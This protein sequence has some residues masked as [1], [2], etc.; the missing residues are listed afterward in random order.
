MSAE[1]TSVQADPLARLGE[2]IETAAGSLGDAA[3]H[4][5]ASARVAALKV[6]DAAHSGAYHSA[7]GV[8]FG[9]VFSAV[10]L[11]ELLPQNNVFRRGFEDGAEEG[12]D[13]AIAKSATRKSKRR[14]LIESADEL[15]LE[16]DDTPSTAKEHADTARG[17]PKPKRARASK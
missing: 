4:A 12:F 8:A 9:V 2:R 17:A 15:P 11:V 5:T 16:I 10:F 14:E 13:A 3:T 1:T 6:K 7:Y